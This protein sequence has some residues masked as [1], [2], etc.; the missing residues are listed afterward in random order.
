MPP[1]GAVWKRLDCPEPLAGNYFDER[2]GGLPIRWFPPG[3][4]EPAV[5][6]SSVEVVAESLLVAAEARMEAP[7]LGTDPPVGVSSVVGVPVFVEVTNWQGEIVE[8]PECV[9]GVCVSLRAT[10]T[11]RFDPGDGSPVVTCAPPG[12]RYVPGGPSL[13]EQAVGACAHVYE[14]RSGVEGRPGEWPGVVSVS[15]AVSWSST[16][17]GVPGP[18]GSFEPLVLSAALPRAVEE[19]STVVVDGDS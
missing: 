1:P 2:D 14:R 10:P 7:R 16:V 19:V 4:G 9:S 8:G 15:W 17:G 6:P 11:L 5:V 12:S 3:G 13:A 18:S